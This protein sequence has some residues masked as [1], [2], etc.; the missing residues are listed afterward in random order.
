MCAGQTPHVGHDGLVN[1]EESQGWV[2]FSYGFNLTRNP[3]GSVRCGFTKDG[4][5]V[6]LQVVG[7]QLADVAV[8]QTMASCEEVFGTEPVAPI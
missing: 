4:M 1:G 3:A 6:G 7:R 2:A 8:L 5:P